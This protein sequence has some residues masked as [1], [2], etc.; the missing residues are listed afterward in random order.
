MRKSIIFLT[1]LIF[2]LISNV[3]AYS[4]KKGET[5]YISINGKDKIYAATAKHLV[6]FLKEKYSVKPVVVNKPVPQLTSLEKENHV[7]L[8]V[9]ANTTSSLNPSVKEYLDKTKYKRIVL[10]N[11]FKDLNREDKT[12]F[13]ANDFT[14]KK[15]YHRDIDAVTSASNHGKDNH[16]FLFDKIAVALDKLKG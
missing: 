2:A 8:I 14:Y 4:F 16:H 9:D 13:K 7:I 12:T 11:L 10:I 5:V 15:G 6:S 1:L 3:S